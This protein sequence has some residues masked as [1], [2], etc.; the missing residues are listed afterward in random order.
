MIFWSKI[1]IDACN[2]KHYTL[3]I[4]MCHTVK[5]CM[6]CCSRLALAIMW[7]RNWVCWR[8]NDRICANRGSSSSQRSHT[9]KD[10]RTNRRSLGTALNA[11]K[12]ASHTAS[13]KEINVLTTYLVFVLSI[14]LDHPFLWSQH[15]AEVCNNLFFTIVTWLWG[16]QILEQGKM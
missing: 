1:K 2:F 3:H 5:S 6:I 16:K 13:L 15:K 4:L 8:S 14:R 12:H 7:L 10:W 9:R 11:A